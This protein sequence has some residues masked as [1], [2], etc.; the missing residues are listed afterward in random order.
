VRPLWLALPLLVCG[1]GAVDSVFCGTNT[2]EFSAREW[3]LL[4]SLSGLPEQPPADPSNRYSTNPAA[5]A[6]GKQLFFDPR[7]S[8]TATLVDVLGRPVPY[9]RAA[10][11]APLG[12]SCSTCHDPNAGGSDLSSTP[13]TTSIGGGWYDVNGQQ[14]VNAA[15]YRVLYWNGRNDSL[16]AQVLAVSESPVSM[17]SNR[18][19]LA[20]LLA[21][22]YRAAYDAVFTDTPLPLPG[23]SAALAPTLTATGQCAL[24]AGACPAGCR[25]VA[26]TPASCWPRFPLHGRPGFTAGC[27]PGSTTEPFS[28]AWDCMDPVDQKAATRVFVNF[29]KAISAY[30]QRLVSRDSAFDRFMAAGP[31]SDLLTPAQQRG[32]RLFVGKAACVE[33]HSTPLF[34]D[35][36]FHNTGVPQVGVQ[37]PTEA[38]CPAGARCDCVA[39]K[40]CLPWGAL[41]GL[42]KLRNNAFRRDSEWSDD[43]TDASR[44]SYLQRPL[45]VD[46]EGAWRTPSLRDVELTA[47]YMHDGAYTSL[48]AVVHAYNLGGAWAGYSGERSVQVQPLSLTVDEEADLTSFLRT[49]TGAPLPAELISRPELPP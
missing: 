16:W 8:G 17:A 24:V 44:Q 10:K 48:E 45:T 18:L 43:R 27:Q 39:G 26:S 37:V 15:F 35:S 23:T 21:D 1:C 22:H 5:A 6:L 11:G 9:A 47:P 3:E 29:G 30:E 36:E 31:K 2:C 42:A 25:A 20:W 4:R 33:C 12:I 28:D 14:T 34:S 40:N 38:D 49:L 32:A 19:E 7:A 41:D 13:N 46:L